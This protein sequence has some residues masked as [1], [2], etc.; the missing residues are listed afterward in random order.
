MWKEDAREHRSNRH[1]DL[2]EMNARRRWRRGRRARSAVQRRR[3]VLCW[4]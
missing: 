4:I 2:V 1:V 3:S